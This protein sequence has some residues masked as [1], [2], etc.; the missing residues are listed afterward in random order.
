MTDAERSSAFLSEFNSQRAAISKQID[1]VNSKATVTTQD[2]QP[3]AARLQ[4]LSSA[5]TGAL[6]FLPGYDQR[7]CDQSIKQLEATVNGLRHKVPK[8][9]FAFKKKQPSSVVPPVVEATP[10]LPPPT[11]SSSTSNTNSTSSFRVS[12]KKGA[13]IS[14][15]DFDSS[16]KTDNEPRDIILTSLEACIVDLL[17]REG[18]VTTDITALYGRGLRK[19]VI[20]AGPVQGSVRLEDCVNCQIVVGCH[21]FRME[22]CFSTDVY[23]NV[24]SLPVIEQSNGVRFAGYPDA[25]GSHLVQPLS[26]NSHHD[27]VKDFSWIKATAS[28]NWSVLRVSDSA[29]W[30]KELDY[31]RNAQMQ[32]QEASKLVEDMIARL[33]GMATTTTTS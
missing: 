3:I 25:I 1:E 33:A 17:P 5:L 27:D 4:Q 29:G 7:L 19:C 6:A 21:Q 26:S 14:V 9:R 20:L 28:P 15:T 24:S 2:I 12:D 30:A 11:A 23:L 13:F 16:S 22:Q 18:V 8:P 32:Q 31:A 10:A